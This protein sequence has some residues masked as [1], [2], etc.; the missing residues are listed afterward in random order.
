M[1][2]TISHSAQVVKSLT[3][4]W[5]FKSKCPILP[6]SVSCTQVVYLM[7]HVLAKHQGFW[8]NAV[9]LPWAPSSWAIQGHPPPQEQK[10]SRGFSPNASKTMKEISQLF[11]MLML[12]PRVYPRLP[13]GP[14]PHLKWH[15]RLAEWSCP[16][17]CCFAHVCYWCSHKP[18][19]LK[20]AD[21]CARRA[22]MCRL[23]LLNH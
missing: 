9:T 3:A 14:H 20:K 15:R 11:Q 2:R 1:E 8:R 10:T 23:H 13:T 6:L 5:I 7:A 19:R 22:H 4:R 21:S 16:E 17:R 12:W 18:L